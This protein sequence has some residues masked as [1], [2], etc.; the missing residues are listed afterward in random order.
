M[1]APAEDNFFPNFLQSQPSVVVLYD[2]LVL[3]QQHHHS[4]EHYQH[5]CK[6]QQ[7]ALIAEEHEITDEAVHGP[8]VF[9]C[10]YCLG[11]QCR[12]HVGHEAQEGVAEG[13]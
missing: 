5:Q 4:D 8:S 2:L 10:H 6:G 13:C 7:V 1:Q 3:D 11:K 12:E 9:R